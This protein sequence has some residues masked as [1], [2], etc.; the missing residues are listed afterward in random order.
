M[1][2]I[3]ILCLVL[4]VVLVLPIVAACT[5]AT[6]ASHNVKIIFRVPKTDGVD[7][8]GEVVYVLDADGNK[9]YDEIFKYDFESIEG[10]NGNCPS[11]LQVAE[12][13]LR[14][15]EKDYEL[16]ADGHS[17]AA[18]FNYKEQ[19]KTDSEKGYFDFW[20]CTV[21]GNVSESGRQ[22]EFWVYD[23]EEVVYTWTSD[24]RNRL[25]T[26]AANTVDPNA[27]TTGVIQSDDT[28]IADDAEDEI[29]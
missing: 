8:N 18:A 6:V 3:R 20:E 11:A 29:A 14:K 28:T 12:E 21:N 7:E 1:N 27:E 25:D 22:S 10:T 16:T 23:N 26:T 15:F 2:K 24:F 9:T 17:I 13:A 4:A 19:E 5:S